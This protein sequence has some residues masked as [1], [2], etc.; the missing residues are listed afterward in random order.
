ML[1]LYLAMTVVNATDHRQRSMMEHRTW[2]REG[3]ASGDKGIIVNL[4]AL[5]VTTM[6]STAHDD[7]SERNVP[8][9]GPLVDGRCNGAC[10]LIQE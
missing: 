2:G 3:L 10:A 6:A 4:R 1:A 9:L 5:R 8:T 7:H